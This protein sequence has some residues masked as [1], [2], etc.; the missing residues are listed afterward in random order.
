MVMV[1]VIYWGGVVSTVLVGC[2]LVWWCVCMYGVWRVVLVG[3][4]VVECLNVVGVGGSGGSGKV[5]RCWCVCM[6]GGCRVCSVRA[7][8]GSHI[9]LLLGC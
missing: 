9:L 1:C 4:G 8:F 5:C 7:W 6:C 2:G 3:G